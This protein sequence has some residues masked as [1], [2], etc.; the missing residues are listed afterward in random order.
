MSEVRTGDLNHLYQQYVDVDESDALE[1]SIAGLPFANHIRELIAEFN[2]GE[3]REVKLAHD[4]DKLE[5]HRTI[6]ASEK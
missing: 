3:T 2:A 5:F 6:I 1:H 4:A